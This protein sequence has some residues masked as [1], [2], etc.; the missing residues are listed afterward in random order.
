MRVPDD[1]MAGV[2]A[3]RNPFHVGFEMG[4]H[5]GLRDPLRVV[6]QGLDDGAAARR[7]PR[8]LAFDELAIVELLDD[9]VAGRLGSGAEPLHFPTQL[10]LAVSLWGRARV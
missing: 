6:L 8:V 9:L 1:V 10:P 7:G 4:G 2:D 5:L 3:G